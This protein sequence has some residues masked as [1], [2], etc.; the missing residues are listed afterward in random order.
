VQADQREDQAGDQQ[1]VHRVEACERVGTDLRTAFEEV[2][3]ERPQDGSRAVQIDPDYGGPV[4]GLVPR[5]QVAREPLE[6]ADDQQQH[7]DD[8]VQLARVL[9]RAEQE[10]ARHVEEHQD[11]ED[12]RAPLV[13]AAHEPAEREVV[14]DLL[15]RL[16]RAVRIRLVVHREDH[17]CQRLDQE[18]RQRRRAQSVEPVRVAGYLAEKEI[19][20]SADQ[21]RAFFEPVDRIVDRRSDA[22]GLASTGARRHQCG[23]WIGYM[24]CSQ[25]STC[26]PGPASLYLWICAFFP[27]PVTSETLKG[28]PRIRRPSTTPNS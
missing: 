11:D 15:D 21:P 23:G 10:H 14:C 16:V 24:I 26:W 25:P 3:K 8:P 13:H 28:S 1:H 6:H 27:S 17:A 2:R 7:A 12:T 9:V 18:R 4:R 22:A 19:L 20:E 5:Q